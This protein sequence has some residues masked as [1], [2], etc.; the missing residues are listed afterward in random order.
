LIFTQFSG[1][2][3]I[4]AGNGLTK[5]GDTLNVVGSNTIIA[6]SN[7]LEINS[8]NTTNQVLLSS[9][10]VGSSATFGKLPLNDTNAI[11][12]VLSV[13]YGGI[14]ATNL[15]SGYFLQ[16]NGTNPVLAI[17]AVPSGGV[18]GTTD[19]QVISNKTFTD[20]TTYFQDNIDNSKKLQFQLSDIST[21]TT[22]ILSIPD[23]DTTIVGTDTN[24]TLT[25]KTIDAYLN[26]I[27]NIDNSNIRLGANIDATKIA[28]GSVTDAKFKYLNSVTSDIQEQLDSMVTLETGQ[29]VI[30]EKTIISHMSIGPNSNPQ[31]D[32]ILRIEEELNSGGILDGI[33]IRIVADAE[34]LGQYNVNGLGGYS[35]VK[36]I[37]FTSGSKVNGLVYGVYGSGTTAGHLDNLNVMGLSTGVYKRDGATFNVNDAT[38]ARVFL[39]KSFLGTNGFINATNGYVMKLEDGDDGLNVTNHYGLYIEEPTRG[40]SNYTVYTEGGNHRFGGTFHTTGDITTDG[41]VNGRNIT[42]DGNMLDNHVSSNSAHGVDGSIVGTTD[43]QTLSNK[44]FIDSTTF[45]VDESDNTKKFRFELLKISTATTRILTVP[46]SNTTIVGTN[47]S[48]TLTNKT[49]DS[50][51]IQNNLIMSNSYIEISEISPPSSPGNGKGRIY[52]KIGSDGLFYNSNTSGEV[53][54]TT[55]GITYSAIL[56]DQKTSGTNGGTFA[57]GSWQTRTFTNIEG[58]AYL[59]G[60]VTLSSNQITLRE[61]IYHISAKSVA[62]RVNSNVL[63]FRN[64]TDSTTD[65]EGVSS[66]ANSSFIGRN[67]SVAILE[68]VLKLTSQKTF[69]LQHYCTS[70]R[71]NDGFGFAHGISGV[72]EIYSLATITKQ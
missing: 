59:T 26:T 37:N 54:L 35:V 57:S 67:Q 7:S 16:G 29:T 2:G 52:K 64:V 22:R 24:Q 71:L 44:N 10:S 53:D 48:Q 40:T 8:S 63:R 72:N 65:I 47:I 27:I 32:D 23:D 14:G 33:D 5:T 20:N 18:V 69:E 3:S 11:T 45:F 38:G 25:N 21:F 61:G 30:G 60:D 1:A 43:S 28:D 70:T 17:K 58:S 62:Y 68:G 4:N 12:G 50:P 41:T 51:T 39:G 15:A 31:S 66:Y 34:N 13:S 9:G 56:R 49:L 46:N 42:D 6:N 55:Q 19:T 36:G